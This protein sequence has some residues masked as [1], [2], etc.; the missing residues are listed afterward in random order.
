MTYQF[1]NFLI[2]ENNES[3]SLTTRE[4]NRIATYTLAQQAKKT[5]YIFS[6][7]LDPAVYNDIP[8]LDAITQ[9]AISSRYS[10]IQILVKNTQ[11]MITN[12]HRIIETARR[13]SSNIQIRKVH[14]EY[15]KIAYA[16]CAVDETGLIYNK[17]AT[18]YEAK[19]DFTASK[20]ARTLIKKFNDI[21]RISSPEP[22]LKHLNI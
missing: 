15:Q 14:D 5:I 13:V 7:Q 17:V 8:L 11:R 10:K 3:I 16:F 6:H 9:L 22:M 19:L 18:R 1:E 4:E 2:G 12:R 20:E 21:W